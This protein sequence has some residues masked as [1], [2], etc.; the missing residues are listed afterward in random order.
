[1]R[2]QQLE[3]T[4][5]G[6]MAEPLVVLDL[7]AMDHVRQI[8]TVVMDKEECFREQREIRLTEE[9][10][11]EMQD[12]LGD[13]NASVTVGLDVK[14]SVDYGNSAGCSVFV[15]LTCDQSEEAIGKA[16]EIAT[17]LAERWVD[18]GQA[19][20]AVILNRAR[21]LEEP[22]PETQDEVVEEQAGKGVRKPKFNKRK[23]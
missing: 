7:S 6:D 4:T 17:G 13:G 15:K 10:V 16:H 18:D 9:E 20:A 5:G 8:V 19:R 2:P 11:N 22:E 23:G 12:I 1:M 14:Q 3:C 21:G